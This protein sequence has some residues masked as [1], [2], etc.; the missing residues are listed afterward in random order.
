VGVL[1]PD[2]TTLGQHLG[3]RLGALAGGPHRVT[4]DSVATGAALDHDHRLHGRQLPGD[5]GELAR[6]AHRLQV[7]TDHR[8]GVVVDPVLHEVVARD[9][10][11]VAGRRE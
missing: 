8:G 11:A 10:D 9:V 3:E 7:E 6:V 5:P 1:D 4:G 2:D